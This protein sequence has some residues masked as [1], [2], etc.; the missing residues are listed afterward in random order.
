MSDIV[1]NFCHKK[2]LNSS[3]LK[4]HQNTTKYCL[5]LQQKNIT[6]DFKCEYCSKKFTR[7]DVLEEHLN[8]CKELKNKKLNDAEKE[9]EKY[10]NSVKNNKHE[11]KYVILLEKNIEELKLK[12]KQL[13]DEKK[14]LIQ[15]HHSMLERIAIKSIENTKNFSE[16]EI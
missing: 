15:E 8:T 3:N 10:R 11:K 9:L 1:C 5:E 12:I 16:E 2:F 4:K 14:S 13:E 7:K 6:D